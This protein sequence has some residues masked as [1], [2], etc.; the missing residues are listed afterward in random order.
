M[1]YSRAASS[2]LFNIAQP[3]RVYHASRFSKR[4]NAKAKFLATRTKFDTIR[5]GPFGFAQGRLFDSDA[6]CDRQTRA[7]THCR[8]FA[9]DDIVQE[10]PQSA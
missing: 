7:I 8:I 6:A 1:S 3:A 9:Q 2:C 5:R 10:H 4:G